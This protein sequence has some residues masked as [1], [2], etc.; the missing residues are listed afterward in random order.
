MYD[1]CVCGGVCGAHY[2]YVMSVCVWVCKGVRELTCVCVCVALTHPP[3][4]PPPPPPCLQYTHTSPHDNWSVSDCGQVAPSRSSDVDGSR[5]RGREGEREEEE[6]EGERGIMEF[7]VRSETTCVELTHTH[8]RTEYTRTH[9]NTHILH[10]TTHTHTQF[11]LSLD[12][13]VGLSIINSVPEELV[14]GSVDGVHVQ[15]S[16]SRHQQCINLTIQRMQVL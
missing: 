5:E 2:G 10:P 14:F 11:S 15:F 6:E 7:D 4:P 16:S 1:E 9:R 3:P 13:G 12:H 8:T